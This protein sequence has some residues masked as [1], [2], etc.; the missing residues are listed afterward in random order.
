MNSGPSNTGP[1]PLGDASPP[2]CSGNATDLPAGDRPGKRAGERQPSYHFRPEQRI[3]RS[4]D[5]RQVFQRRQSVADGVLIVYG[6]ISDSRTGRLGMSISR[7]YGKAHERNLWKRWV[8][9][10]FRQLAGETRG[11]DLVVLPQKQSQPSLAAITIS[12][13]GLIP[14]VRRRLQREPR[15]R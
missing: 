3:R 11:L 7:K 10:A 13:R 15:G 8:R 4:V 9:E 6:G 12:L 1:R 14:R 2:A 5:F